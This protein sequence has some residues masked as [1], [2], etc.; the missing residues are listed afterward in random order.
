MVN[1]RLSLCS[2]PPTLVVQLSLSQGAPLFAR[3]CAAAASLAGRPSSSRHSSRCSLCQPSSTK[4]TQPLADHVT[5]LQRQWPS[6]HGNWAR[7]M[8]KPKPARPAPGLVLPVCY[9]DGAI[10]IVRLCLSPVANGGVALLPLDPGQRRPPVSHARSRKGLTGAIQRTVE[11]ARGPASLPSRG[12]RMLHVPCPSHALCPSH[13]RPLPLH[14]HTCHV[15]SPCASRCHP[16]HRSPATLQ[17]APLSTA[18]RLSWTC[19][20]RRASSL[21]PQTVP[22][23]TKLPTATCTIWARGLGLAAIIDAPVPTCQIRRPWA[24]YK[25]PS[26][27]R[28]PNFTTRTT[29]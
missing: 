29:G 6:A 4:P 7:S 14:L 10:A 11:A 15:S 2:A 26:L 19:L 17:I 9:C 27:G 22:Q 8:I 21:K 16:V 20:K 28:T 18:W 1:G 3:R 12:N 23:V 25:A 5:T 24:L 13:V